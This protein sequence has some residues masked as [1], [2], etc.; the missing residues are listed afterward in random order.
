MEFILID[1]TR[2]I[3]VKT[4]ENAFPL[5]YVRPKCGK[6]IDIYCS[7]KVTIEHTCKTNDNVPIVF[8]M[9]THLP[10]TIFTVTQVTPTGLNNPNLPQMPRMGV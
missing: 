9:E 7:A 2:S 6:L 8:E 5:L 3:G 4:I 10:I 1:R